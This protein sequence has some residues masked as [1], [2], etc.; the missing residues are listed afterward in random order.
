[1]VQG[2]G[3][4]GNP[5]DREPLKVLSDVRN[6]LISIENA[7]EDYGVVIKNDDLTIDEKATVRERKRRKS[8]QQGKT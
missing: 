4:Y 6:D 8:I 5:L 2:G 3:G 7:F 1:M